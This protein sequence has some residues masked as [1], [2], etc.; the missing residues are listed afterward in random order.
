AVIVVVGAS[1]I[2]QP[3][4]AAG[5]IVN[6]L[7]ASQKP[8]LA[9]VSPHAPQILRHLNSHGVPTFD[10]PEACAA[11]LSALYRTTH[12][13]PLPRGAA[14]TPAAPRSPADLATS[15]PGRLNEE[16]SS[17]LLARYGIP[18]VRSIGAATP[19]EAAR[20]AQQFDGPVVMKVLSRDIAHKSDV[21]GVL[22]GV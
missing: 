16:Q 1:S 9:Y 5:P 13:E 10:A 14:T 3:D 12:A 11:A 22:L 15:R 6:S 7:Q 4:L 8:L 19:P 18:V 2:A 21:G 17:H 20:A